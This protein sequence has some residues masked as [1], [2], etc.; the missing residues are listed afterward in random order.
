MADRPTLAA[1]AQAA[2]VRTGAKEK[3]LRGVCRRRFTR[4]AKSEGGSTLP[5][6]RRVSSISECMFIANSLPAAA[7]LRA[8]A[9]HGTTGS[10]WSI[11]LF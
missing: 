8:R 4:F 9:A 10:G 5:S 3:R 1:K 7:R 6:R 11:R 2:M